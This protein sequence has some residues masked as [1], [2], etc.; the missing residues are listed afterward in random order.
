VWTE[1]KSTQGAKT[2]PEPQHPDLALL[3]FA[4]AAVFAAPPQPGQETTW[5]AV[6]LTGILYLG[7][8]LAHEIA[9]AEADRPP[10]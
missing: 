8:T 4:H 2:I 1:Y 5:K 10:Q 6:L 7:D 3:Q 9:A